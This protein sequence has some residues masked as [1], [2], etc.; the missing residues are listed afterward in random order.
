MNKVLEFISKRYKIIICVLL[1]IILFQ[2]CGSCSR[3]QAAAFKDVECERVADSLNSIINTQKDSILILN[4]E[5][6]KLNSLNSKDQEVIN[7][8][9]SDKEHLRNINRVLVKKN[10]EHNK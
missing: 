9:N 3:K 7:S 1:V 8:L 2:A 10:E 4:A 6:D 5:I